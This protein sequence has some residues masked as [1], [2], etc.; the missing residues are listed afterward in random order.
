MAPSGGVERPSRMVR[1]TRLVHRPVRVLGVP[2]ARVACGGSFSLPWLPPR[3]I[4]A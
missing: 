1:F 2:A 4:P 3:V